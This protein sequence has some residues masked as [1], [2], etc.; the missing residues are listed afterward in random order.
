MILFIVSIYFFLHTAN[1]FNEWLTLKTGLK[2]W[3][4][5]MHSGL[6]GFFFGIFLVQRNYK[7]ET[8]P[9]VITG[10]LGVLYLVIGFLIFKTIRF[11][12]QLLS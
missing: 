1:N 12:K 5:K 8:A 10:I 11:I 6:L 7:E 4:D 2:T 9:L 3:L